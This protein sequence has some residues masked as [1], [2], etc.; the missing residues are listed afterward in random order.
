LGRTVASAAADTATVLDHL[1]AGAFVT[2]GHSG[3]GPHALA[4]AALLPDRCV[5]AA[6][7]AGVARG[8]P[9]GST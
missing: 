7:V 5:A 2:M 8:T 4:C 1:G 3:G 6:S 9:R